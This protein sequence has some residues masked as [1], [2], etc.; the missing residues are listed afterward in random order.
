M[1]SSSPPVLLVAAARQADPSPAGLRHGGGRDRH[2]LEPGIAQAL[3]DRRA[4]ARP[5]R[6]PPRAAGRPGASAKTASTGAAISR[7]GR[8]EPDVGGRSRVRSRSRP[9]PAR[10]E[11]LAAQ[12]RPIR[13]PS[14]T[15][16]RSTTSPPSPPVDVDREVPAA[17]RRAG[18][19]S[20][21]RNSA[22]AEVPGGR[23]TSSRSPGIEVELGSSRPSP[24]T[25]SEP[26]RPARVQPGRRDHGAERREQVVEE[27]GED[28]PSLVRVRDRSRAG[29]AGGRGR[30]RTGRR[31]A[32]AGRRP[33]PAPRP[34][35]ASTAQAPPVATTRSAGGRSFHGG[36]PSTS[37]PSAAR[38]AA[39]RS[40]TPSPVASAHGAIRSSR[41]RSRMRCRSARQV[42]HR[43]TR[44][45]TAS[46][47]SAG[48]S[49]AVGTTARSRPGRPAGR[50]GRG[51]RAVRAIEPDLDE[52]DPPVEDLGQRDRHAAPSARRGVVGRAGRARRAGRRAAR[53]PVPSSAAGASR[54]SPARVGDVP[55]LAQLARPCRRPG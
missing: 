39:T 10:P 11:Q 28:R 21:N 36:G 47:G 23:S 52:F 35:P 34:V 31:P 18:P 7:R 43:P 5:N 17:R 30:T 49:A 14:G 4:D 25:T 1:N 9:R 38:A 13:Q 41:I 50:P 33:G 51:R 29:R 3:G 54:T 55:E 27:V 15:S 24:W 40:A 16:R 12:V 2:L 20:R 22:T 53:R 46:S 8:D 48:A 37:R 45:T 42:D 44:S 26:A 19:M 32:G 6:R